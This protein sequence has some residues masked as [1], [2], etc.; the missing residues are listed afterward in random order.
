MG[1]SKEPQMKEHTMQLLF[2]N[3]LKKRFGQQVEISTYLEAKSI[4]ATLLM[5]ERPADAFVLTTE[6]WGLNTHVQHS[7]WIY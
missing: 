2:N 5:S 6:F 4:A 3:D 1:F 7:N